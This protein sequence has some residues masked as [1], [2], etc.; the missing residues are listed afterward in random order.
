V[1]ILLPPIPSV[2]VFQQFLKRHRIIVDVK[3]GVQRTWNMIPDQLESGISGIMDMPGS[4]QTFPLLKE[5]F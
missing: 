5:Y 4:N 2:V 1:I 3:S